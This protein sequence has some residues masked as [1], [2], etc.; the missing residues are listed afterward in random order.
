MSYFFIYY[1]EWTIEGKVLNSNEQKF[2]SKETGVRDIKAF[3]GYNFKNV[4]FG[5]VWLFLTIFVIIVF[6]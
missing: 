3:T 1:Q 2:Y 6:C 4:E 5:H